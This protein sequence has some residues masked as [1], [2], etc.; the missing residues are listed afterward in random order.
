MKV[1]V[2]GNRYQAK[3]LVR[4]ISSFF[5]EK[6][7]YVLLMQENHIYDMPRITNI[8]VKLL[9]SIDECVSES[10][11]CVVLD[12]GFLPKESV[13]QI[14]RLTFNQKKDLISF[15]YA[16]NQLYTKARERYLNSIHGVNC[17]IILHISIGIV[18]QPLALE[19]IL[20]EAMHDLAGNDF[21]QIFSEDTYNFLMTSSEFI[22]DSL[23]YN[24]HSQDLEVVD[25]KLLLYTLSYEHIEE[26]CE[27]IE[28]I[29]K[30]KPD[31]VLFQHEY[32]FPFESQVVNIIK[33]SVNRFIDA[34]IVSHFIHNGVYTFYKDVLP[35][36][37]IHALDI[38]TKSLK[39]TI[40]EMLINCLGYPKEVNRIL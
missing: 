37:S 2:F 39:Q 32:G 31:C 26:F 10:D 33:Y 25:S 3:T 16:K 30:I 20:N 12:N 13:E 34:E 40:I 15:D 14:G 23:L 38:E 1:F 18:A 35:D 22:S 29:M 27:N 19:M 21:I 24:L 8:G 4:C 5:K 9:S 11:I 7:D 36:I 28:T 17:P 6:V